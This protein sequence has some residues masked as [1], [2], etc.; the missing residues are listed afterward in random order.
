MESAVGLSL[1]DRSLSF[2]T[3]TTFHITYYVLLSLQMLIDLDGL[4][5]TFEELIDLV[6]FGIQ[7]DA[8]TV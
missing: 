4:I 7:L 6:A 1:L 2:R 5:F 3:I 8:T